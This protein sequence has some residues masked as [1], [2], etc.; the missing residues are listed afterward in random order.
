MPDLRVVFP[1]DAA[2]PRGLRR[3]Q[4]TDSPAVNFSFNCGYFRQIIFFMSPPLEGWK[5]SKP[6]VPAEDIFHR[7]TDGA[8]RCTAL[9]LPTRATGASIIDSRLNSWPPSPDEFPAKATR[10]VL[11]LSKWPDFVE[12]DACFSNFRA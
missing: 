11:L 1:D 8:A 9:N 12:K 5:N 4:G 2:V 3:E 6:L 10:T 7:S